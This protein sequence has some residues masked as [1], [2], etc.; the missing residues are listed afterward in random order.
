ML[1]NPDFLISGKEDVASN[2][3]TAFYNKGK[4]LI[5]N[6]DGKIIILV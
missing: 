1:F 3:A 2:Y 5:E 6:V 4:E